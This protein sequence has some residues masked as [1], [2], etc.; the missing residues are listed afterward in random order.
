MKYLIFTFIIFL[1]TS[2]LAKSNLDYIEMADGKKVASIEHLVK[3]THTRF[4]FNKDIKR[5]A[6]GHETTL[7]VQVVDGREILILA[8]KLGRTSMMVWYQD[9]RSETFLLSVTEDYSVLENA[10]KDIHPDVQLT[11]APDRHAIVLRG[12]VPT[13][14]F[15]QSAYTAARNYLY[16][17]SAQQSQP[18]LNPQADQNI[19]QT[20]QQRLQGT[21]A[22][23][24]S[25]AHSNKVAIINLIKVTQKPKKKEERISELLSDLGAKGVDVERI[26]VGEIDSDEQ[27]IFM[28]T[29]VVENQI[30]LVRVL[31]AVSKLFIPAGLGVAQS[32]ALTIPGAGQ[33][34][35]G[36][37]DQSAIEVVANESGALTAADASSLQ[38]SNV[39]SNVARAT[40]LSLAG[41]RVLSSIEVKDLPQIRVSV[42]LY[43][44]NQRQLQ[45]WRPDISVLTNGYQQSE[46]LFG[47]GGLKERQSGSAS[48]ENALQLVSGQ[49]AN[50]LQLSTSQFAIDMLFSLLEQE[51]I[52]RTLSRPTLTVLAGES[53]VFKVGGEIPVP[54]TYSPSGVQGTDQGAAGS[55]FSGTEFK[56]FGVELS[57]R[58][59]VDDKDR[60]T[61]DLNPV[62]SLPDTTLTAQIAQSS[63]S[64]LNSSAFNTRSMQTSARLKDGQPLVVGG[65]L[66]TDSNSSHDFVPNSKGKSLFGKLSEATSNSANNRELIIVVTPTLVREPVNDT[67]LWMQLSHSN[68]VVAYYME[69]SL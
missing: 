36:S 68:D 62:I 15:R 37:G 20:L 57:V 35:P 51:G 2:T 18:V 63:G 23:P 8:K 30:E 50:N 31:S 16:A 26:R 28:L 59:L 61:L 69:N 1:S 7:D 24:S 5:V 3:W 17:S 53:A 67:S 27:D 25:M 58:A 66:S 13:A 55:V 21:G 12:T 40:L 48:I 32:A 14:T 29:G 39:K 47:L 34:L 19:L 33:Q 44:I 42:Q 52:S 49:F 22:L 43:E 11:I 64:D 60:I 38:L 56:S 46:G 41:G 4:V 10:L 54:T 45:Q 9:N 65:L 6:V